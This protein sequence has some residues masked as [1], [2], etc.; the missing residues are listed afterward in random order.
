VGYGAAAKGNTLLNFGNIDFDFVL[1]DNPL[2]QNLL[3]PGRNIVIKSPDF[4]LQLPPDSKIA[5]V[6]LAW[7]FYSEI[8]SRIK[9]IRKSEDDIFVRYFPKLATE[10]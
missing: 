2:K 10:Q 1:D 8:K 9:K 4:L 7:N 5:F 3:T 6:P